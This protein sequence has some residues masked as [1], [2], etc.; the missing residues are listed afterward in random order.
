MTFRS[1]GQLDRALTL[2]GVDETTEGDA[3]LSF[4]LQVHPVPAEPQTIA[5][6]ASPEDE[7]S[8]PASVTFAAGQ[9]RVT[10]P[11]QALDD[12]G[13][14]GTQSITVTA[15]H[16]GWPAGRWKL[17]VHDNESTPLRLTLPDAVRE[18][19]INVFGTVSVEAP[20]D[21]AVRVTSSSDDKTT[22]NVPSSVFIAAGQQ[23]ATFPLMV[24]DDALIN[25]AQSVTL[26]ASVANWPK[27]EA[28][29]QFEDDEPRELSVDLPAEMQEN[30]AATFTGTVR[31]GGVLAAPLRVELTSADILRLTVTPSVTIPAGMSAQTFSLTPGDDTVID[32]VQEVAVTASAAGFTDGTATATIY[33]NE[34]P[35]L[36]FNPSPTNGQE[37][38][39][40][41]SAPTWSD[42]PY[43]GGPPTSWD[44]TW[45]QP[46]EQALTRKVGSMNRRQ[47]PLGRIQ[48]GTT[49]FWRVVAKRGRASH[50]GPVWSFTIPS[51][52]V[53]V[54]YAWSAIATTQTVNQPFAVTVTGYDEISAM[55]QRSMAAT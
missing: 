27:A 26:H 12:D 7:V 38:A 10:F 40:P 8:L 16:E 6:A 1:S 13:I 30:L 43:T 42:M 29:M 23:F 20:V 51:T 39:A 18:G 22:V 44:I 19:S 41:K 11:V 48:R 46:K 24:S 3:P 32:G 33:D 9:G 54:R 37:R 49:Y 28:T 50:A 15:T 34:T 47:W 17:E 25:P 21:R 31:V 35:A 45:A 52:G 36:P 5:L 55:W 14:D 53:P 2:T 4:T